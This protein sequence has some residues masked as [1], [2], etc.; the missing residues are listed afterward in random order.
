MD[1]T[2][3]SLTYND[4]SLCS[5]NFI[6]G[7]EFL[8]RG[9]LSLASHSFEM[10]REQCKYTNTYHNKYTSFCGYL[11]ILTGNKNGLILCRDAAKNEINDGDVFLNLARSELY[12][13]DRRRTIQSIKNGLEIDQTHNALREFQKKIGLRK[14]KIFIFLSRDS[15]LNNYI[16]K[17]FRKR[18]PT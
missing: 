7:I 10:A 4:Y 18:K 9:L 1:I 14:K 6:N 3:N 11:R 5:E 2:I 17:F 13:H 12:Y 8:N 15:F 16:G